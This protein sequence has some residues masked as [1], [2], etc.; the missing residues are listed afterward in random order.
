MP[1]HGRPVDIRVHRPAPPDRI[2]RKQKEAAETGDLVELTLS[3]VAANLDTIVINQR[4]HQLAS[5]PLAV[6][7]N[8]TDFVEE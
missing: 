4:R 1:R 6:A 2:P 8:A 7:L 3:I 5:V